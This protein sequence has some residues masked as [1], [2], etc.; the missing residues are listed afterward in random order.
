MSTLT[1]DVICST[2]FPVNPDGDVFFRYQFTGLGPVAAQLAACQM[3]A[4]H[5]G[6]TPVRSVV[7]Y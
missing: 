1:V 7:L 4:N 5:I 6:H 3:A 2:R